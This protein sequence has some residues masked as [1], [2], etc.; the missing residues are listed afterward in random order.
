MNPL[1]RFPSEIR[2]TIYTSVF[3]GEPPKSLLIRGLRRQHPLTFVSTSTRMETLQL[4]YLT[5]RFEEEFDLGAG[6]PSEP[7][8]EQALEQHFVATA[9]PPRVLCVIVLRCYDFTFWAMSAWVNVF[10]HRRR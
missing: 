10:C 5:T 1:A 8:I 9:H 4:Y 6:F 7:P 3:D 2:N